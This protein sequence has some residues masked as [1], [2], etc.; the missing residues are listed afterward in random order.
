M[1]ALNVQLFGQLTVLLHG[2]ALDSFGS[3]KA[4]E[5]F[6]Y[7]L[8]RGDRSHA[9]EPLAALLWSDCATLQSKKYLRQTLWQLQTALNPCGAAPGG[10]VLLAEP[11][12]VQINRQ[13]DLW[14]DVGEFERR[15][16]AAQSPVEE[17]D[18][19][20]W[21]LLGEAVRLYRGDLL[22]GWYQDWCLYERER[23]Q[24]I[25]LS[26]LEKLMEYTEMHRANEAGLEWGARI[27]RYDRAH[28]RTHER[29]MRLRYLAGDRPGALRQYS[30]C[31]LAL[32]EELGIGP[33][34]RTAALYEQIRCDQLE[35][36][37]QVPVRAAQ[38][39]EPILSLSRVLSGLKQLRSRL[40]D[41]ES[42]VQQE[43]SE[44]ERA[45]QH[46]PGRPPQRSRS[47]GGALRAPGV[48]GSHLE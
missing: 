21:R 20:T 40:A 7:L 19:R 22:E 3:S 44:V 36:P 2:R 12:K 13:A 47:S 26:L 1:A 15:A 27:L 42:D 18:P 10:R 24:S 38:A 29:M 46:R 6:C 28:E 34:K 4:E 17:W 8:I 14:T 16:V 35:T 32:K 30:R 37:C 48:A 41:L 5:L 11:D 31:V 9:R 33:S 43:V 25:F 39:Q 23:L 45:L